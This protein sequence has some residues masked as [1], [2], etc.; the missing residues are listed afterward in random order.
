[1]NAAAPEVLV[2]DDEP[3]VVEA[4]VRLL[5]HEGIRCLGAADGR[6]ALALLAQDRVRVVLSDVRMPDIDG[7][8]LAERLRDEFD[9]PPRVVFLT[10]YADRS[11]A[12]LLASGAVRVLGKPIDPATLLRVVREEL[13]ATA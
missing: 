5:E 8:T 11:Q 7:P 6:Q 13:A 4:I 10:A 12:A 3:M 9:A 1:M 2:V